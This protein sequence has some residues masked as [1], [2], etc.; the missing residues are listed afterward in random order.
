MPVHTAYVCRV[1]TDVPASALQWLDLKPN[2]SQRNLI[3]DGPGQT[4]YLL[5][6]VENST[7]AALAANATIAEYKGLAAYLIDHIIDE[8]SGVTIT[9]TVANAAAVALIARKNAG[10][11][12]DTA[13]L[14]NAIVTVGGAGAGTTLTN[15]AGSNGSLRDIL[16]IMS[17]G[18]YTL[19][20]GSVVGALAVPLNGGS[21]DD[22]VYRQLYESGALMAS[23]AEGHLAGYASASFS[24]GGT[25]GKAL[26][27]YDYTGTALT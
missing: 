2:T 1:R 8:V 13:G 15:A 5:D 26:V 23:C 16:K 19:P 6:V 25:A 22:T 27:V 18:K 3:Y 7:L 24:Y 12:F 4:G 9:V 14:N 21:F 11:A 17:G 20:T 10:T